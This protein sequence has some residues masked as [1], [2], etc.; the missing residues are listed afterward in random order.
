MSKVSRDCGDGADVERWRER[1]I[2]HRWR[3]SIRA[4]H[5]WALKVSPEMLYLVTISPSDHLLQLEINSW[6]MQLYSTAITTLR[7]LLCHFSTKEKLAALATDRTKI[8]TVVFTCV[9]DCP[10]VPFSYLFSDT[11]GLQIQAQNHENKYQ[12]SGTIN[13]PPEWSS[14]ALLI[15]ANCG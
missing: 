12:L 10:A 14:N 15:K 4:T 13:Y 5:V 11:A 9:P 8:L 7:V 3:R 6:N 2:E 1:A